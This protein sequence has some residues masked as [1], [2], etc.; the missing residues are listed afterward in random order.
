MLWMTAPTRLA[1]SGVDVV[2]VLRYTALARQAVADGLLGYAL[3][4]AEKA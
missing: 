4:I 2:A 3:L 1:V